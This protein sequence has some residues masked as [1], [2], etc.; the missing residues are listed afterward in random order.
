MKRTFL[1]MAKRPAALGRIARTACL[2]VLG[3]SATLTS[4]QTAFAITIDTDTA[5][6]KANVTVEDRLVT[7]GDLFINAGSH[8]GTAV[9][10]SPSL[11]QSGSIKA[12]L[13]L[14][15]ALRAGLSNVTANNISMVNVAR[16]SELVTEADI[17]GSVV[18]QLKAKGYVSAT[19]QVDVELNSH[20]TDQHAAVGGFTPFEVRNLRF[21]RASGRFIANLTIYGRDDLGIV[22]LNGRAV[23]TVMVPV[24]SRT[25]RRGEVVSE[26]DITLTPMPRQRAEASNPAD[27]ADVV[28]KAVKQSLRPGTIASAAFFTEPDMVKRSDTVTIMFNAGSLNL[29]IMGKAL[30][31]GTKG[32]II[33]VQNA[34]TNRIIRA[35]IIG[36]G[37]LEIA[38]PN[39]N[40]AS[41]G[42]N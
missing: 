15:A 14:E 38:S 4:S 11:G 21:D 10:R 13:V 27:L 26:N 32:D 3:F 1:D 7:L 39:Q 12:N 28:G 25:I 35:Q 24:V 18:A 9:F 20:I 6:L 17:L 22:H 36:H 34:Q 37:L 16:A 19:A 5:I 30:S 31:D 8:A 2:A 40:V 23:E 33:P 41:L 29:S 42:A